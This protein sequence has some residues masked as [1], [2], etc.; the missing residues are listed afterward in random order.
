VRKSLTLDDPLFAFLDQID[1]L[2]ILTLVTFLRKE[3]G[4]S[5]TIISDN[6]VSTTRQARAAVMTGKNTT[7]T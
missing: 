6:F 7:P 3:R 2:D 4:D 1:T 5:L